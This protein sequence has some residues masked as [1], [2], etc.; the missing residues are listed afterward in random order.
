MG[1]AAPSKTKY[2]YR[3]H[4]RKRLGERK[5]QECRVL[6][7]GTMNTVMVEFPDGHQVITSRNAVRLK[8]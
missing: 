8:P 2:P 5:G 6:A 4:W 3:W 7:K 1:R